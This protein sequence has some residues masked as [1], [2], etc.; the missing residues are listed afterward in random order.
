MSFVKLDRGILDSSLWA[1]RDQ[2]DIFITALLSA[3]PIELKTVTPQLYA[4]KLEQTGFIIPLGWYGLV[5]MA[6]SGLIRRA[7]VGITEG[8]VALEKLGKVDPDSRSDDFEGRRL[9]RISGGFLV[10]NYVKY[11]DKD[12]G[13]AERMKL[14]RQRQ[15]SLFSSESGEELRV[16]VTPKRNSVT[17]EDEYEYKTFSLL[18]EASGNGSGGNGDHRHK[19]FKELIFKCYRYLNEEDPPWDASDAKQLKS[20][21]K[22]KPDLDKEKFHS[23]L[24]NYA[25]SKDIN[26]SDRPRK[27]LPKLPSY[28]GGVLNKFGRPDDQK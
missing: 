14:Y 8:Y 25:E 9:V 10:L 20:L 11:R 15:K 1:D 26:P 18:P 27:F 21:I 6:P 2:R 23:W 7:C 4:D 16:T 5:A 22:A 19:D 24:L 12:H 13:A 17:Y 3:E 28:A